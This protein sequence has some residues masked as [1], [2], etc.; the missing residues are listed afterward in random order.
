MDHAPLVIAQL[1]D[2][3]LA[4]EPEATLMG[5][6]TEATLAAVIADLGA[7]RPAPEFVLATGDLSETASDASYQRLTGHLRGLDRPVHCLP[8]NH[9]DPEAMER[10]LA[11]GAIT[12]DFVVDN[13]AWRVVLLD[14]HVPGAP[15]GRLG[16][17]Q[18]A[19]LD[20]A[21]A[22]EPGRFAL[23]A[24]HHPPVVIASPWMDAMGL[25]DAAELFAVLDRHPCVR[26]VIWGHIHQPF[27]G[28][29]NGVRLLGAPSTSRQVRPKT[30]TPIMTGE[31]PAWRRLMLHG[32]GRVE[33]QLHWIEGMVPA[34]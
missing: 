15:H 6:V 16:A 18:L 23:I 11:G 5:V 32:D 9:D 30:E 2:C 22:S 7:A 28:L 25:L 12:T 19:R 8:G 1:T 3:H 33:T 4:D 27:E 26:A 20:D 21:L 29:R 17:A 10:A 24:V 14:S 31:P 34:S 13:G